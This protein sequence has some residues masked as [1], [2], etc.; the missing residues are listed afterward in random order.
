MAEDKKIDFQVDQVWY[1]N[2]LCDE[3]VILAI[4]GFTMYLHWMT[5]NLKTTTNMFECRDDVFVR[6]ISPLE[7][8]LL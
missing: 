7:K 2:H 6:Y 4:D 8:E 1:D 3:Y 5:Y